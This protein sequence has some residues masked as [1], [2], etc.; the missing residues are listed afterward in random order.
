MTG[1]QTSTKSQLRT[2]KL[3]K[4][5]EIRNKDLREMHRAKYGDKFKGFDGIGQPIFAGENVDRVTR[6]PELVH[7]LERA[8]FATNDPVFDD[9]IRALR[10][11]GLDEGDYKNA[12]KENW[13]DDDDGYLTQVRYLVQRRKMSM[14]A[15]S[16]QVVSELGIFGPNFERTVDRI[17]HKFNDWKKDGYQPNKIDFLAGNLGYTIAVAAVEG[18]DIGALM[19][20]LPTQTE[21]QPATRWWR[22]RF[23]DGAVSVRYLGEK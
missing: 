10:A 9:A 16:E 22:H 12:A 2:A 19:R 4:A 14:R 20:P 23:R 17:R 21:E 1:R 15:A 5:W 7:A 8:F 13:G 6:G 11:Y 3:K 18:F